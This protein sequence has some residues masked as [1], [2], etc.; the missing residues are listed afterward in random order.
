M[1]TG[2]PEMCTKCNAV[3]NKHSKINAEPWME[4]EEK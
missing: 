2:D 3:F 1:A 4:K